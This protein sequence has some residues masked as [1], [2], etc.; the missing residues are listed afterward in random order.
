MCIGFGIVDCF[1]P[2]LRV[3]GL[4]PWGE[5]DTLTLAQAAEGEQQNL[6]A[7]HM[8]LWHT[9]YLELVIGEAARARKAL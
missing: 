4:S 2:P 5:G 3:L 9:D 8:P 6:S 7:L 1:R